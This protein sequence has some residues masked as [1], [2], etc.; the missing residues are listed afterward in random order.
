LDELDTGSITGMVV[1]RAG[2]VQ[3]NSGKALGH[4]AHGLGPLL[5]CT[6]WLTGPCKIEREGG[7]KTHRSKNRSL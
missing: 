4:Q 5:G 7:P 1:D 2:S 6:G 3:G